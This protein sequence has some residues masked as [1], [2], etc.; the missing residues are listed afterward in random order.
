MTKD[1]MRAQ[2]ARKNKMPTIESKSKGQKTNLLYGGS[3]RM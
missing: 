1:H 2:K 3:D